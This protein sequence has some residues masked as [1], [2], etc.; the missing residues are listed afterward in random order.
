M[1]LFVQ[2]T[3]RRIQ[4]NIFYSCW[5][6]EKKTRSAVKNIDKKLLIRL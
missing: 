4:R 1:D 2:Q 3:P 5:K 6:I